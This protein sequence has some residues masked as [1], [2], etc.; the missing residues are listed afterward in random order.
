LKDIDKLEEIKSKIDSIV[1]HIKG[2]IFTHPEYWLISLGHDLIL[3]HI[4]EAT[5]SLHQLDTFEIS[6]LTEKYKFYYFI[7]KGTYYLT[8]GEYH[9]ALENFQAAK[10]IDI[11]LDNIEKAEFYFKLGTIYYHFRKTIDSVHNISLALSLFKTIPGYERRVAACEIALG[12]NCVNLQQW[13]EAEE[14]FYNALNYANK[15]N[16]T[17]MKA[18]IFHDLGLLYAEQN[19]SK[20]AVHWFNES[21]K[22][23]EPDHKTIYLLCREYFKLNDIDNGKRWLKQ[24][25]LLSEKQNLD[26]YLRRFNL[27]KVLY[28]ETNETIFEQTLKN[29]IQFFVK[30]EL[31]N[32]VDENA[33]LLADFYSKKENYQKAVE[34]YQ[35][36][37]KA[38]KHI[39]KMGA[40]R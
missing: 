10:R 28:L 39:L 26:V 16:D 25:I 32:H 27:L 21:M 23:N 9:I 36:M 15:V 22:F 19:L 6:E 13:E 37:I 38:Q 35:L 40:L 14:R 1:K 20:A 3:D 12:L 30:E 8:I 24:G 18:L 7:F 34:Y 2:Y 4:S 5:T 11:S 31:W 33:Q 29:E 17:S